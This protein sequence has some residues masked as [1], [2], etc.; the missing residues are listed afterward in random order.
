MPRCCFCPQAK[1]CSKNLQIRV[2]KCLLFVNGCRRKLCYTVVK[3]ESRMEAKVKIAK[4]FT[5]ERDEMATV[6]YI[7][8]N[9]KP[10]HLSRTMR[11]AN[12]FVEKYQELHPE[13]EII[14]LDL[15][16]EKIGF[17]QEEQVLKH[18]EPPAAGSQDP[19]LQYAYQF[20]DADKYIIAAPFWNLSYPAILKAYIDYVTV[21]GV[22][23]KYTSEG[24]AGLLENKKAVYFVTRGG[25][26]STP[27]F[28]EFELGERYLRTILG[29][30]GI[31]DFTTFAADDMDRSATDVEAV[32]ADY[33][34]KA[35]QFAAEF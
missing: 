4:K 6:L 2:V 22:T 33:I 35:A 29:F 31:T 9:A 12:A 3:A 32:I 34:D 27:P 24:A 21:V 28:S 18:L 8:A 19:V 10:D 20:R 1:D 7:K 13:D 26:Y 11:I 17:L 30:M 25:N 23:F 5:G 16:K 15:Y 14:T